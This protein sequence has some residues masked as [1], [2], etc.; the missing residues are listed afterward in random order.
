[1]F[2]KK[3]IVKDNNTQYILSENYRALTEKIIFNNI[4]GVDVL[5]EKS[6]NVPVKQIA[7]YNIGYDLSPEN[8]TA[9]PKKLTFSEMTGRKISPEKFFGCF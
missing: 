9:L 6:S 2:Q 7:N 1:M 4:T 3:Q 8:Y 5:P